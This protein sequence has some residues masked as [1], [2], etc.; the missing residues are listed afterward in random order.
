MLYF[1]SNL[2]VCSYIPLKFAG[3]PRPMSQKYIM[4]IL[5]I[6]VI[7][8]L[9]K[10]CAS[11]GKAFLF[12]CWKLFTQLI[13]LFDKFEGIT[14]LNVLTNKFVLK[15]WWISMYNKILIYMSLQ[16][17]SVC[18]S[19]LV[20]T[21]K[22][23]LGQSNN[24]TS[25]C[26]SVCRREGGWLPSTGYMTTGSAPEGSASRGVCVQGGDLHPEVSAS[27]GVCLQEGSASGGSAPKGVGQT[28]SPIWILRDMVNKRVVRILLECILV[29]KYFCTWMF[30]LSSKLEA[31]NFPS[32]IN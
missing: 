9:G 7:Y 1:K 10:C 5:N 11:D 31:L 17:N 16:K 23:S 21:S 4:W 29:P 8:A 27:R 18:R 14:T 20:T 25:S 19:V 3:N 12:S 26:H 13:S 2:P 15:Y 30:F 22:R 32:M 28:P 6:F 24:F